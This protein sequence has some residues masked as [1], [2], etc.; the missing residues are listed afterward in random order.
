MHLLTRIFIVFMLLFTS[1][2]HASVGKVSLL[3]GEAF[4]QRDI[5]K[6]ALSNNAT[7]EEKDIITT[8][9]DAQIQIIFEDKTV[10]TLGSESELRIDE[11]LNDAQQSRVKFKFNQGTF[12]TI[13]GTIGKMT[14]GSFK[15]ETKTAAI[16]IRG[17]WIKG[18]IEPDGDTIGCLRGSIFVRSLQNGKIIEVMEGQKT[19]VG[20]DKDPSNPTDIGTGDFENGDF[21]GKEGKKEGTSGDYETFGYWDQKDYRGISGGVND[22]IAD[23]VDPNTQ[24]TPASYIAGLMI[25]GG[26]TYTYTGSVFGSTVISG[27]S[28]AIINTGNTI[29][30]NANFDSSTFSGSITFN[31]TQPQ[32]WSHNINGSLTTAGFSGTVQAIMGASGTISG[33]FYGPTAGSISGSFVAKENYEANIATGTFSATR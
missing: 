19:F 31:S 25:P 10:V 32:A 15:V 33:S 14:P 27:V 9:K 6:S 28:G 21:A 8:N 23:F 22:I 7:L 13:T 17:T 24:A 3:K 12:K 30:L 26:P 2:L 11:Y 5:I 29:T 1:I 16:G 18:K 4:V 20:T